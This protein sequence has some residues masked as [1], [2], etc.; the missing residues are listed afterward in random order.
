MVGI[1][2]FNKKITLGRLPKK[3]KKITYEKGILLKKST[4]KKIKN[5]KT[6]KQYELF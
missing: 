6:A 1:I 3:L 4:L 2:I 5:L